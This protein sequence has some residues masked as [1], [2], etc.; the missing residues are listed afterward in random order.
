MG[1][2]TRVCVLIPGHWSGVM[3]GAQYQAKCLVE[4]MVASGRFEVACLAR[5]LDRRHRPQGYRL[6]RLGNPLGLRHGHL[7]LDAPAILA[8]LRRFDPHV[9][10]QR[11]GCAYAGI[12]A[13]HAGRRGASL[14]WQVAHDDEVTPHVAGLWPR[15]WSRRLDKRLLEYGIRR[16]DYIVAQTHDQ[17]RL[18]RRH[19][20][21]GA[22]L[23]IRNFHPLPAE[24]LVKDG[25]VR[26]VWL[27]N[28]KPFKRPELFLRLAGEL[29]AL[30]DCEFLMIGAMQ[31]GERW[32]A[33]IARAMAA[34]PRLRWLG[35]VAQEE[36]NRQLARAH[37]LVNTSDA[38]GFSNT[39]IQAWMRRVPVVSLT[40]DPD[41]LLDGEH[42]GYAC[43][44][45]YERLREQ[46]AALVRD[47]PLRE[48]L[49]AAAQRWA[50]AHHSPR[51]AE[52]FLELFERAAGTVSG[53]RVA[54]A[55]PRG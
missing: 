36:A 6:V 18:L 25:P 46:V 47:R 54:G 15:P 2:R 37:I 39:F 44:G 16:A 7:Y 41:G 52:A 29:A 13:F 10:Y 32:R 33:A 45:S 43:A 50:L 12:A 28:L 26:V 27:A 9:I 19:Y 8:A 20:G 42:L 5:N 31:G 17:D 40:V 11:V 14:V 55:L 23:V 22:S 48:R 3:G 38:E 1:E 24:P 49:G 4:A 21:R 51:N 34:V 53:G 30:P 35:E